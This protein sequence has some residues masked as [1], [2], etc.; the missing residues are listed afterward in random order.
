ML[1]TGRDLRSCQMDGS[2]A[3]NDRVAIGTI[4]AAANAPEHL[5]RCAGKHP[6]S[7]IRGRC[8]STAGTAC[9]TR[10]WWLGAGAAAVLWFFG[11]TSRGVL[12]SQRQPRCQLSAHHCEPAQPQPIPGLS[13]SPQEQQAMC[14]D[15]LDGLHAPTDNPIRGIHPPGQGGRQPADSAASTMNRAKRS[16][17]PLPLMIIRRR[18]RSFPGSCFSRPRRLRRERPATTRKF[19]HH[20][21]APSSP[22]VVP[23]ETTFFCRSGLRQK[24][25][26]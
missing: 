7:G 11:G 22:R 13:L 1:R 10:A 9:T 2:N 16:S 3:A 19:R 21:W 12:A 20:T 25:P 23:D 18:K 15:C 14:P 8:W 24:P 5:S 4:G 17:A 6:Q 26:E